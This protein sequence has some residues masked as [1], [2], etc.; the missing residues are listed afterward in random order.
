VSR[1]A[2][3]GVF[4]HLETGIDGLIH[5][6]KIVDSEVPRVG[7]DVSVTVESVDPGARRMSLSLTPTEVPMGY[8]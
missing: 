7:E 1:I 3:F 8:K 5:I 4:I 6:S 2:S